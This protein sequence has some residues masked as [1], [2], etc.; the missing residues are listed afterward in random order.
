MNDI[1]V[2]KYFLLKKKKI[3]DNYVKLMYIKKNI[4]FLLKQLKKM[5]IKISVKGREYH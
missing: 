5:Y 4:E 1:I 2:I 3:R